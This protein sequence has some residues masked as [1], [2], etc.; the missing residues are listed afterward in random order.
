MASVTS[1]IVWDRFASI[2]RSIRVD[3]VV[4][5]ATGLSLLICIS[6]NRTMF[7][8]LVWNLDAAMTSFQLNWIS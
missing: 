4:V 6:E 3:G 1:A 5:S 8:I 7:H 2:Q